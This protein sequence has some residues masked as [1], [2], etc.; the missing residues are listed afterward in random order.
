MQTKSTHGGARKNAGRKP[1]ATPSLLKVRSVRLSDDEVRL[2]KRW[3]GGDMTA[4][5]RVMI[6]K[7]AAWMAQ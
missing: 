1:S 7:G 4:G 5:I 6:E 2:L 3:G